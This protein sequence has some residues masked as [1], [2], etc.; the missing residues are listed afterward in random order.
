MPSLVLFLLLTQ[1]KRWPGYSG[2]L[3]P[4]ALASVLYYGQKCVLVR[5]PL[6]L[7]NALRMGNEAFN[8][9]MGPKKLSLKSVQL[10]NHFTGFLKEHRHF[11]FERQL[12]R[13][14]LDHS[15]PALPDSP[16][17]WCVAFPGASDQDGRLVVG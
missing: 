5:V 4:R 16:S 13:K 14:V 7:L 8:G 2:L 1:G 6:A 3:Q 15:L 11:L 9:Y 17:R 10:P 12:I